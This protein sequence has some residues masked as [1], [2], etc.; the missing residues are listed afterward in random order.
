MQIHWGSNYGSRTVP[1][2]FSEGWFWGHSAKGGCMCV[3]AG[4]KGSQPFPCCSLHQHSE[5]PRASSHYKS[6][7]TKL[8]QG[9]SL[10]EHR[11]HSAGFEGGGLEKIGKEFKKCY[12]A[13]L[14]IQQFPV[15]LFPSGLHL[16]HVSVLPQVNISFMCSNVVLAHPSPCLP[17]PAILL[18]SWWSLSWLLLSRHKFHTNLAEPTFVP[19]NYAAV[20]V[21]WMCLM[22][23]FPSLKF[24]A[25]SGLCSDALLGQM[26][27]NSWEWSEECR[28]IDWLKGNIKVHPK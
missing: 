1:C 20:L 4:P 26:R 2:S 7:C 23:L 11:H 25:W 24:F 19:R 28:Y 18:G 10:K 21:S 22:C 6:F 9:Y 3:Q 13:A 12:C 16:C 17:A 27:C 5:R 8:K 14:L 15:D